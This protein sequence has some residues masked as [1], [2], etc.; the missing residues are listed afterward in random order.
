MHHTHHLPRLL[1]MPQAPIMQRLI[2][3]KSAAS[4]CL[5]SLPLL[6]TI[7][8]L[9]LDPRISTNHSGMLLQH[10]VGDS[11]ASLLLRQYSHYI[12]FAP[13]HES[14]CTSGMQFLSSSRII[15]KPFCLQLPLL[16]YRLSCQSLATMP[17]IADYSCLNFETLNFVPNDFIQSDFKEQN[18]AAKASWSKFEAI[19]AALRHGWP[20]SVDQCSC[21]LCIQ[22]SLFQC[23]ALTDCSKPI[24]STQASILS[25][26]SS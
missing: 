13:I 6:I 15:N 9:H 8:P 1:H 23:S 12:A 4:Q 7:H 17:K 5:E 3:I 2:T 19:Q 22:S 16:D 14:V 18:G 11:F 20:E 10:L 24:S 21:V 25:R 26:W